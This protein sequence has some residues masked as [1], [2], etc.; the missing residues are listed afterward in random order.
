MP[1]GYRIAMLVV[2][3]ALTLSGCSPAP[4]GHAPAPT[5]S[6]PAPKP[7]AAPDP[8]YPT[9]ATMAPPALLASI[10]PK[11]ALGPSVGYAI[12]PP[13]E[14]ALPNSRAQFMTAIYPPAATTVLAGVQAG[15]FNCAWRDGD[16]ILSVA[17]L[18]A[19]SDA[20]DSYTGSTRYDIASFAGLDEGDRSFGGC[21]NGEGRSCEIETL[22]GTT[23]IAAQSSTSDISATT[24]PAIQANLESV[25]RSSIAAVTAAGP[26]VSAEIQPESRWQSLADCSAIDNAIRAVDSSASVKGD[27]QTLDYT[28]AYD[29]V[30]RAAVDQSGAFSCISSAGFVTVVPGAD[31]TAPVVYTADSTASVSATVP[32]VVSARDSCP[33]FDL[34]NCWTEGYI[35]HALVIVA[36]QAPP[37]QRHAIL[38]AIAAGTG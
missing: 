29:P 35:D 32:G 15:Y 30:F 20:F 9:C 31:T 25:I 33:A 24:A 34:T 26:L 37:T 17:V 4:A 23:W 13:A 3:T 10:D 22:S 38:T 19:A 11:L 18:P 27:K 28:D 7:V 12:A 21:L 16:S 8:T 6:Q 14:N 2:A 1:R 36:N 5:A